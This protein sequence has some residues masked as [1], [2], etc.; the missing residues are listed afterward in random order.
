MDEVLRSLI[1]A[2]DL[3]VSEPCAGFLVLDVEELIRN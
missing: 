2:I 1:H 3:L